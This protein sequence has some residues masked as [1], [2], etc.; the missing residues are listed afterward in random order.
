MRIAIDKFGQE[1]F[2]RLHRLVRKGYVPDLGAQV[3]EAI[4]LVHPGGAAELILYPD[5]LLVSI[6]KT[7]LRPDAKTD[8]ERIANV[9]ASDRQAFDRF[10]ATVPQATAAQKTGAWFSRTIAPWLFALLIC[11]GIFLVLWVVTGGR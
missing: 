3:E 10:L 9:T 5:G 7:P 2:R 8:R 11:G 1:T 4:N 6:G